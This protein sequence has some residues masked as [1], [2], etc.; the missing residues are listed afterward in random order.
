M[1]VLDD[2]RS[3]VEVHCTR[4]EPR[5]TQEGHDQLEQADSLVE[6]TLTAHAAALGRRTSD[7]QEPEHPTNVA[8]PRHWRAGAI[9]AG[10]PSWG[11]SAGDWRDEDAAAAAGTASEEAGGGASSAR[12]PRF[13][14]ATEGAFYLELVT[15]PQEVSRESEGDEE[16]TV[17]R[18]RAL[19]RA[20]PLEVCFRHAHIRYTHFPP[21][22]AAATREHAAAAVRARRRMQQAG[23]DDSDIDDAD[24]MAEIKAHDISPIVQ[25]KPEQEPSHSVE[26]V[27]RQRLL[28]SDDTQDG[29]NTEG[30][31]RHQRRR[32]LWGF[33]SSAV[34]SI[35]SVASTA[36][37]GVKRGVS[38]AVAAVQ[39][40]VKAV[41]SALQ[42]IGGVL[43]P[44][45]WKPDP[46]TVAKFK[47]N[48]DE[49]S[50]AAVEASKVIISLLAPSCSVVT[51]SQT[52]LTTVTP[53]PHKNATGAVREATQRQAVWR[54]RVGS[55]QADL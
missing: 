19:A 45:K 31:G 49:G 40:G 29:T 4:H 30:Q 7:S 42:K 27:R 41:K 48:Y 21:D 22:L 8:H 2:H 44:W 18:L 52:M 53:T 35:K 34:K 9:L 1:V 23:E 20:V 54:Q 32:L 12:R 5:S 16:G 17:V 33:V 25:R 28:Y 3:L 51:H 43:P 39:T 46:V 50:D 26:A 13:T 11:C 38:G 55:V 6:V 10:G 37:D 14:S 47:F 36:Y 15:R 24:L